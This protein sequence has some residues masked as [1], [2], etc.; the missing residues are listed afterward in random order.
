[1][2]PYDMFDAA[3]S[4]DEARRADK[5]E[6]IYHRGQSQAWNGKELLAGLLAKHGGISMPE[7]KRQALSRI[8][9]IL[10]WG[11]LAAWRISAQLADRLTPLEAK[12][13]ATSQAF[14]EARHFYV[15]HDYLAALGD[16][17]KRPD[18]ETEAVLGMVLA[19]DSMVEKLFGMQL[20]IENVALTIFHYVRKLD[21][22]PVLTELLGYYERDEARHVGLGI[23]ELPGQL[24]GL[25]A[26]GRFRLFTFQLRIMTHILKSL[27]NL[28]PDLATLGIRAREIFDDGT[29]K[30]ETAAGMMM[31][32]VGL[33]TTAGR[34]VVRRVVGAASEIAFPAE[35]LPLAARVKNAARAAYYGPEIGR[36]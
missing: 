21:V 14:D 1:M 16:L 32:E 28:E 18:P 24:K 10:M 29:A 30:V 17:P 2:L 5:L 20:L 26:A 34:E 27:K 6:N 15:L 3:R 19:T 35:P 22:E 12:M 8:F 9:S 13:A 31:A 25:S 4:A 7:D 11:E 33:K 36:A 23:Q